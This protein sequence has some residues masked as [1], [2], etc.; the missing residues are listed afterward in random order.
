[1]KICFLTSTIFN[2]GGV[3]RVLSVISSYLCENN[4]VTILCTN[5][6]Y[7]EDRSIYNLNE[8][9]KIVFDSS[10]I[11]KLN[12]IKRVISKGIRVAND[13]GISI[14]NVEQLYNAYYRFDKEKLIGFLNSNNF[15]I[16]VG[17][18]GEFSLWV[19]G[20]A[21]KLNAKT[22]GWQHNS[23]DAYLNNPYRYYWKQ[24]SVFKKYL[25]NLDRYVVLN[26]YDR[27]KY[28]EEMNIEC[29]VI[30]NPVSF[31]SEE[32]SKLNEKN[33]LAAGRFVRQKGFDMLIK[34][35]YEFSKINN[36]WTLTIVG[37]GEEKEDIQNLINEYDLNSRVRIDPFTND[38]KSYF[39]KSSALLLSS[40]WE[41]MPMIGL[42]ALEMG[43]PII[44]FDITAVIPLINNNENGIIVKKFDT[45]KFAEAM[46]KVSSSDEFRI[47]MGKNA[48]K[49][50]LEFGEANIIK[51]WD[52]LINNI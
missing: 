13:K 15:D 43:V 36:D 7:K 32:K 22:I 39:L 19:S 1:M 11:L 38:I 3:Q 42:E 17:V 2:L 10:L 16:V 44:S 47:E 20:I 18:E 33:F 29:N 4:D 30:Y 26:E 28:K 52:E 5:D 27:D 49:K 24:K 9:V 40:R 21:N 31:N 23:Y 35:F 34:S 46:L 48:V 8:K 6:S 41:G 12:L 14:F 45:N 37:E 25:Q 51:Q 50:S